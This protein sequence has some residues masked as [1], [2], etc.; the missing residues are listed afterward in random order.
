MISTNLLF[1]VTVSALLMLSGC[2]RSESRNAV[3]T[4]LIDIG[5]PVTWDDR[6]G[7]D[8]KSR[9]LH[10]KDLRQK[11]LPTDS[12]NDILNAYAATCLGIEDTEF[13]STRKI[14]VNQYS[15]S[16]DILLPIN[17]D[18]KDPKYELKAEQLLLSFFLIYPSKEAVALAE[19]GLKRGHACEPS[20]ADW[21]AAISRIKGA[22][23][24]F[25]PESPI[26]L[27]KLPATATQ[28]L[29]VREDLFGYMHTGA[30]A[31]LFTD[32]KGPETQR[33]I[34]RLKDINSPAYYSAAVKEASK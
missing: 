23:V 9:L 20:E 31:G 21:Q 14:P 18:L 4:T 29:L 15:S 26:N 5:E 3:A 24:I 28:D 22:D 33:L 19:N 30:S 27:L 11:I 2:S 16:V 17:G 10:Y 25:G 34:Q 6:L 32:P 12:V 7:K 1:I 8:Y 13:R